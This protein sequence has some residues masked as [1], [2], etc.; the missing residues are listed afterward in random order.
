MARHCL[1]ADRL[2]PHGKE[3]LAR[4]SDDQIVTSSRRLEPGAA[5][6]NQRVTGK[7][8]PSGGV[9]SAPMDERRACCYPVRQRQAPLRA[10]Y[11]AEPARASVVDMAW[12]AGH[13]TANP[14][15]GVAYLGSHATSR[16]T[17]G[18]H[19]AIGGTH[20]APVRGDL[21]CAALASCQESSLRMVANV[22]GV[23]LLELE[24]TVRGTVDVRGTLGMAADVPV[25]FQSMAV[26]V[27]LRPVPGTHPLRVRQLI[28]AAG[29]S[30]VVLQTLR[31]GVPVGVDLDLPGVD[32][33]T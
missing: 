28:R 17:F 16:L 31:Q 3:P 24:V 7:D 27:R 15:M 5:A 25:G 10:A 11:A 8:T 23:E 29:R 30:C 6:K 20:A 4:D 9:H 19:Q 22:L 1:R 33:G 32:A 26:R 14:M 12:T 18:V 21:L 2:C 13:D